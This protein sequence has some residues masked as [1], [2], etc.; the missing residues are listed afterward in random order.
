MK[1]SHY[2]H[3]DIAEISLTPADE[4]TPKRKLNKKWTL[5]LKPDIIIESE[6]SEFQQNLIAFLN[7]EL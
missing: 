7:H 3:Y 1:L 5:E 2:Q 4:D 6:F